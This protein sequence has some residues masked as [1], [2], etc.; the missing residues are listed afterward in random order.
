MMKS[1]F[2]A[3][4]GTLVAGAAGCVDSPSTVTTTDDLI[5]HH[6]QN[7]FL[8]NG[9]PIPNDSGYSTTDSS[10]GKIDVTGPFFQNLGTNGRRCVSCHLPTAGWT[11]TP[12][13]TQ[14]IF[15]LTNGGT[16][17]DGFGLGAIF[18][19]ND[20]ANS[21]NAPVG[22]LAQRRAAYSMLL[23]HGVIK[24][25]MPIPAGAEFSLAAV[26]DPYGYANADHLSLF[27]RPLP[28]TNLKFLSTVMWDGRETFRAESGQCPNGFTDAQGRKFCTIGFD[29]ADQSNGATQGHAQAPNPISTET[30]SAIVDFEEGIG[31]AQA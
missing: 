10:Y 15:D 6:G 8:P 11:I 7:G 17:D 29:L 16:I 23:N 5:Q 31:T 13:Q 22:T 27:R 20:G 12:E 24:V 26:D 18:R 9:V 1:L 21:P 14:V 25:E 28:S 3:L 2:M 19:L 30:R 4:G